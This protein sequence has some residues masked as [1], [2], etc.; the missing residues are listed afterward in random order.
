M[1]KLLLIFALLFSTAMSSSPV[2]AE[3]IRLIENV[4]GT[5]LYV[6]FERIR[7]HDGYI[8]YWRLGNYLKPNETGVW[9]EKVYSQVDCK[10]FRYKNLSF[11][12]Y[13]EPMGNGISDTYNHADPDWQYPPP[14]SSGEVIMK[15]VCSQ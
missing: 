4:D 7:K 1:K 9:S 12:F 11:S 8:Y 5:I 2:R 14:N 13:K 15:T 6:D 3:W 10:Q